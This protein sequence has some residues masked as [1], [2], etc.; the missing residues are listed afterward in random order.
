MDYSK[1]SEDGYICQSKLYDVEGRLHQNS[2]QLR[3]TQ[4]CIEATLTELMT[5]LTIG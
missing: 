3:A 4:F 1:I 5:S 2:W